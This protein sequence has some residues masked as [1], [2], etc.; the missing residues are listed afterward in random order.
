MLFKPV[1]GEV[2]FAWSLLSLQDR[3]RC[4]KI[5]MRGGIF[6]RVEVLGGAGEF[7]RQKGLIVDAVIV[8][9]GLEL[10][11]EAFLRTLVPSISLVYGIEAAVPIPSILAKNEWF[12][13]FS[14]SIT[15]LSCTALSLFLPAVGARSAAALTWASTQCPERSRRSAWL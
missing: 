9:C 10:S 7:R 6:S 1:S 2:S 11:R 15:Y 4:L 14:G 8:Q 13:N 5:F 3:D 12:Y